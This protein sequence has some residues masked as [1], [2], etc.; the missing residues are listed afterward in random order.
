MKPRD[1]MPDD[2]VDVLA[3]EALGQRVDD[4]VKSL[5]I[6]EERRDVLEENPRLREIGHVANERAHVGERVDARR[7]DDHPQRR[8]RS[9]SRYA[10][11]ASA[12]GARAPAF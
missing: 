11:R 2:G 7:R 6:G 12:Q 3:D 9:A 4:D 5:G 1:S 8:R 10:A